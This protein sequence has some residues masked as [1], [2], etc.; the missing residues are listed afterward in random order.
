MEANLT[1]ARTLL[2]HEYYSDSVEQRGAL[3]ERLGRFFTKDK[4]VAEQ[5]MERLGDLP[6]GNSP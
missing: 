1:W 2:A 6:A 3:I 5:T 4:R